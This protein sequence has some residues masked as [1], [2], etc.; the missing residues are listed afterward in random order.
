VARRAVQAATSTR[1]ATTQ[2]ATPKPATTTTAKKTAEKKAT[3]ASFS[4]CKQAKAAGAA[5]LYRGGPGYSSKL[6][7]DDDGVACET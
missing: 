1:R 3:A 4:S 2:R 5:P 7:G 6:D